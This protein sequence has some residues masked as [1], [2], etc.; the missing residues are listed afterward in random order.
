MKGLHIKIEGT[1]VFI[2]DKNGYCPQT[3][4]TYFSKPD[5]YYKELEYIIWYKGF[6][7][8]R[9][10]KDCF[11]FYPPMGEEDYSHWLP[12]KISY[13]ALSIFKDYMKLDH[14]NLDFNLILKQ[15]KVQPCYPHET[16][17]M[18]EFDMKGNFVCECC[19]ETFNGS[20]TFAAHCTGKG[21]CFEGECG[22]IF[23]INIICF[24]L[25]L[26]TLCFVIS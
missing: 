25:N 15:A 21:P 18:F 4:V 9:L 6:I 16:P 5:Q 20:E 12:S 11:A 8:E 26:T 24:K 22:K 1:F 10:Y 13:V 17:R 2:N 7:I 23:L 19:K 3:G 14:V